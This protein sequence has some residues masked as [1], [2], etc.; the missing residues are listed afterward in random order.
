MRRLPQ[1]YQRAYQVAHPIADVTRRVVNTVFRPQHQVKRIL[2]SKEIET[3]RDNL[4][5]MTE[6]EVARTV[7]D[8]FMVKSLYLGGLWTFTT[9]TWS[10]PVVWYGALIG[11]EVLI[12]GFTRLARGEN[13]NDERAE[14]ILRADY[15]GE[16]D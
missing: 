8:D 6:Q 16:L 7:Q 14:V 3:R 9:N 12:E 5:S 15:A 2:I 11:R 10:A 1:W 4:E 13:S